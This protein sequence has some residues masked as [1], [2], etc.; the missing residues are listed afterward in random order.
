MYYLLLVIQ[1]I[2]NIYFI[3]LIILEITSI[4]QNMT[5]MIINIIINKDNVKNLKIIRKELVNHF[6]YISRYLLI[7]IKIIIIK[8]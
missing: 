5:K 2:I 4:W 1:H 7:I 6:Y 3:Y 8:L